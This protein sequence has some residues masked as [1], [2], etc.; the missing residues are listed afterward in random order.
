MRF[1]ELEELLDNQTFHMVESEPPFANLDVLES[2]LVLLGSLGPPMFEVE[3][4]LEIL[5]DLFGK[6]HLLQRA[7]MRSGG[8]SL[9]E[10]GC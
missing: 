7:F 10:F 1:L 4:H 9:P 5:D 3:L 2:I 6:L 8:Y